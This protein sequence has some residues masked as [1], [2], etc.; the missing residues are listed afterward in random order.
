MN[1][2]DVNRV[3][4]NFKNEPTNQAFMEKVIGMRKCF[5]TLSTLILAA[6][7]L[8][9][10]GAGS[11]ETGIEVRQVKM[12][13]GAQGENSAI[14]LVMRNHGSETDQLIGAS[15]DAAEVCSLKTAQRLW[16]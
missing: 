16:M 13:A 4:G 9:A 6:I 2:S 15:S 7:L 12:D 10:C 8:T 14:Y 1:T 11:E 3:K 5:F